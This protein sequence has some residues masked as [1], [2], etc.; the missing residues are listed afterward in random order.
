MSTRNSANNLTK[1]P[2][3]ELPRQG[4]ELVK[5]TFSRTYKACACVH[6]QKDIIFGLHVHMFISGANCTCGCNRRTCLRRKCSGG[7][8]SFREFTAES[9]ASTL[10]VYQIMLSWAQHVCAPPMLEKAVKAAVAILP[11]SR[12]V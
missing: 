9:S 10:V 7:A 4:L 6:V 11:S 5:L 3:Q 12:G 8:D 1:W 2:Y